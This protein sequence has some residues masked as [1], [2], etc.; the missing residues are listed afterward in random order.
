[1]F[2]VER[3]GE[4][5]VVAVADADAVGLA[6]ADARGAEQRLPQREDVP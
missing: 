5:P 4:G 2:R 6:A 1:M 3:P